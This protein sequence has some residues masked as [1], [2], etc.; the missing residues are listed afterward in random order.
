MVHLRA[1]KVARIADDI[2]ELQVEHGG[3][4]EGELLVLGWGST[5][6]AIYTAV[7]RAREQ[8]LSVSHAHLRHLSPFPKNLGEVLSRFDKVLIPEL[9]LGQLSLLV[10]GKYLVD[11]QQLNKVTGR[12]FLIREV[13]AKIHQMVGS[14]VS[15]R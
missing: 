13:E 15:V 8:R 3:Q 6:G 7:Q 14:K 2:P 11:A 1:E 4:D 5:Y 10:R 9:N 12:P